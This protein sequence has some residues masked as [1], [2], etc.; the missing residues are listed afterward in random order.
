MLPVYFCVLAAFSMAPLLVQVLAGNQISE[1]SAALAAKSSECEQWR[2]ATFRAVQMAQN[3]VTSSQQA[4]EA[5]SSASPSTTSRSAGSP[6]QDRDEIVPALQL[7]LAA[8]SAA[9]SDTETR[10][11]TAEA[12]AVAL[13]AE[14]ADAKAE[15]WTMATTAAAAREDARLAVE[16]AHAAAAADSGR[17][18]SR[19][20]A[21]ESDVAAQREA[22]H[23]LDAELRRAHA[24]RDALL[25]ERD[26]LAARVSAVEAAHTDLSAQTNDLRVRHGD[27]EALLAHSTA[28][29]AQTES[30][31]GVS[32]GRVRESAARV[33]ALEAQLERARDAIEQTARGAEEVRARL[34]LA[35]AAKRVADHEEIDSVVQGLRA[36]VHELEE[37][38]GDANE[39]AARESAAEA[40]LLR[41][42]EDEQAA[43]RDALERRDSVVSELEAKWQSLEGKLKLVSD[44]G[45]RSVE[46]VAEHQRAAIE[47]AEV[48]F[49]RVLA[50]VIHSA[51]TPF[52]YRVS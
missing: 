23:A 44:Q 29:L 6:T 8:A 38:L 22:G 1:G 16:A 21:L 17:L 3:A 14:L 13:R 40:Q 52:Q 24:D 41:R 10:L 32:D 28:R 35:L 15:A 48:F 45:A 25:A 39:R 19:I 5:A 7:R 31:L 9:L 37:A 12:S 30:S 20:D 2:D 49:A 50:A 33:A 42:L 34:E 4:E 36:R 27:T 26:A 47:R 51:C 11:A 18:Q 43:H 46:A